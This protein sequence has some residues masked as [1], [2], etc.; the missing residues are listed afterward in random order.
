MGSK[1]Q[2]T[3]KRG[4]Q[5]DEDRWWSMKRRGQTQALDHPTTPGATSSSARTLLDLLLEASVNAWRLESDFIDEARNLPLGNERGQDLKART[6]AH[7]CLGKLM[8][9]QN[10]EPPTRFMDRVI[11]GQFRGMLT[12][13][14]AEHLQSFIDTRNVGTE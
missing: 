3:A 1:E 7:Q 10:V 12:R 14:Q 5:T 11:W 13:A 9:K 4:L 8:T 6:A 2:T